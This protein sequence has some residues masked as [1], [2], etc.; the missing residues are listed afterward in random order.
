MLRLAAAGCLV[1]GFLA[2][3]VSTA[4]ADPTGS[5]NG[6]TVPATCNGRSVEIVIN[7]ANGQGQGAQNQDT[8]P[9]APAHVV[10]SNAVLHPTVF[11]LT[12][13]FTDP[14]GQTFTFLDTDAMKNPKT[15][16]TCVIDHFAQTD[17]H[18]GMFGIDGTVQGFFS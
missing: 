11:D 12:F 1:A 4:S 18:G 13:S 17:P 14:S 6:L 2:T 15:S 10:G 5:K 9:F 8:A 16:V 3:A 7:S